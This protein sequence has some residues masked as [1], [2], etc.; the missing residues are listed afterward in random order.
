VGSGDMP[1]P[2]KLKIRSSEGAFPAQAFSTIILF[3]KA[4]DYLIVLYIVIGF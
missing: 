2:K 3:I 1:L 4:D